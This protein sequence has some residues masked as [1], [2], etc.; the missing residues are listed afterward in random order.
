MSR[1]GSVGAEP[2]AVAA[3]GPRELYAA[4][5]SGTVLVSTDGGAHGQT[6]SAPTRT[7]G[8]GVSTWA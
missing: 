7:G 1:V 8:T 5:H 4:V 2:E 6:R 3:N